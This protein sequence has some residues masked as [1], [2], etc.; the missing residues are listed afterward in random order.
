MVAP[1]FS[2]GFVGF[3]PAGDDDRGTDPMSVVM[4][5]PS[6]QSWEYR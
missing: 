6:S 5:F 2:T 1:D 3:G 4:A